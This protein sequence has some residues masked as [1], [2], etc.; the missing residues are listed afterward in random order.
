M[1]VIIITNAKVSETLTLR[2]LTVRAVIT[3]FKMDLSYTSW[4]QA[5]FK[6]QCM[7]VG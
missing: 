5:T 6:I 4:R 3:L 7:V 2:F 1:S